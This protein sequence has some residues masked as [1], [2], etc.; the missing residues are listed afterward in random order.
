MLR[1]ALLALSLG[2]LAGCGVSAPTR[3]PK[4]DPAPKVE[5]KPEPPPEVYD[6]VA[7]MPREAKRS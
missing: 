2:M 5:P 7:P 1:A 4:P 6:T 3:T